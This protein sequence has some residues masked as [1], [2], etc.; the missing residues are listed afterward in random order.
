MNINRVQFTSRDTCRLL[1][2]WILW[3]LDVNEI[4]TSRSSDNT[5]DNLARVQATLKVNSTAIERRTHT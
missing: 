5:L 1:P 2:G 3:P 4:G